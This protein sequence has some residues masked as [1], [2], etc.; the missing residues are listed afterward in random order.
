M[1]RRSTRLELLAVFVAH[2]DFGLADHQ[3]EAFAA[4]GFDQN[5]EL[6]FAAAEHAERFG[7]VGVFDADGN[8]GEQL[9]RR[10]SRRSREVR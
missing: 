8:V 9:L 2:D 4:H 1:T 5:R 7:R 3:L 10:R 6:Q